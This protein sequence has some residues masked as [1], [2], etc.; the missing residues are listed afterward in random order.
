MAKSGLTQA[1]A[2]YIVIG[3]GA[4]GGPLAA[5][6]ARAGHSVLLLEA[7]GDPCATSDLGRWMYEVP[8]F[9]GAATEFPECQWDYFVRHYTNETLQQQDSKYVAREKATNYQVDG[10]WYP[11]AGAL[12]GCTTHNAMITI[13]P[14]DRDW[15]AIAEFTRDDS[16]RAD[17]MHQYFERLENCTYRPRPGSAHYMLD[18]LLWRIAALFKGRSDGGDTAHGHGFKGWLT[19]S[20]ADP[21]TL[22]TDK[23][24]LRLLTESLKVA[25][26]SGLGDPALTFFTQLDPNDL[27]NAIDSKEGLA[28]TPLAVANGKRNGP[29]ELLLR[30]KEEFPSQLTIK[31][32]ALASRILF[33]GTQAIGV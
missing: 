33:D 3:S 17:R 7:G 15:N 12:G 19:T 27:R 4:G 25:L 22:F 10:V 9:H 20:A 18:A 16:W 23:A 14:Q 21:R 32:H 6:L 5:N 31:M 13:T 26:G 1:D 24:L 8:I 11:R 29:R 28:I 30:T 2:D